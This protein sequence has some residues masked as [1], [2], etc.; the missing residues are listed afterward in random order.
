MQMVQFECPRHWKP[1]VPFRF[2]VGWFPLFPWL[3]LWGNKNW[4][5]SMK[6][7]ELEI[8]KNKRALKWCKWSRFE[9]PS[10]WKHSF[11][12]NFKV[13]WNPFS[14]L[15][16]LWGNKNWLPSTGWN[17]GFWHGQFLSS[18]TIHSCDNWSIWSFGTYFLFAC[19][20]DPKY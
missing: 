1:Y 3:D 15:L 13:G 16:A 11:S 4:P 18:D 14:P 9:C 19:K 2:G 20:P 12:S 17:T 5:P 6:V 10:H 7:D 8:F